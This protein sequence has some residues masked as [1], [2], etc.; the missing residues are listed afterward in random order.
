MELTNVNFTSIH[1]KIS[2]YR[3]STSINLG[4][5]KELD[6]SS[7]SLNEKEQCDEHTDGLKKA[8]DLDVEVNTSEIR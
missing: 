7:S 1:W 6:K 5:F 8:T 2:Q 3:T 4:L